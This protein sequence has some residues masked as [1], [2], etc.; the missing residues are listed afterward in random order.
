MIRAILL[1]TLLAI[2]ATAQVTL[3]ET[4]SVISDRDVEVEAFRARLNDPDPDKELAVLRL[5]IVKG[6]ADQRHLAVRDGLQSTDRAI[7]AAPSSTRTRR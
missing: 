2:P 7:R 4:D 3:E 1:S 5:L 6:D